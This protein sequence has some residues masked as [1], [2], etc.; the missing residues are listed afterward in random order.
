MKTKYIKRV[1]VKIKCR[2]CGGTGKYEIKE[3]HNQYRE[4]KCYLCDNGEIDSIEEIDVTEEIG[5]LKTR[6][7]K[8]KKLIE[9]YK[10]QN[11]NIL[12]RRPDLS[13]QSDFSPEGIQKHLNEVFIEELKQLS[14]SDEIEIILKT[15]NKSK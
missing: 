1:K 12:K 7:L 10:T 5:L 13:L 6:I 3:Y 2:S 11:E 9:H 8:A 14:V 4:V 15:L